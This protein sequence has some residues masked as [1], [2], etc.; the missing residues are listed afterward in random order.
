M[1][2]VPPKASIGLE[3]PANTMR[4]PSGDHSTPLTVIFG[5]QP[6]RRRRLSAVLRRGD[7]AEPQ[8][9]LLVVL[10]EDLVVAVFLLAILH[11]LRFRSGGREG[12]ALPV[13]GP[14]VRIDVR[15][16]PGEHPRFAAEGG[17]D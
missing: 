4:D 9:V 1:S 16:V 13:G 3:L 6:R 10:L 14:A 11:G 5:D 15:A 17:D 12:E 7:V 8:L 2:A